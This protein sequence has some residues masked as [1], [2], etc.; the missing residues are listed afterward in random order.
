[1]AYNEK[2]LAKLADLKALGTKQKEV[3]DAL[4]AR[5]DT[6]E[7]VGSQANVLEGVK[8]NGTALAIANKMVDILIATG[9]KNGSISVNGADV[10]IKGLAALAFKAKV[11]QSDLDDALAAVLEGKA[12]KATTLDGYGITNAYTKDEIN[13]KIS[14]VYKPAGSVVFAELPALSE[15]ILGNV[16][17]V[18][19]AFTTTANFVEGIST[20]CWLVS[21]TCPVML[22][23]KQERACLTRTSLRPSRISWTALRLAQ[24]SMSIPPTPLL[25]AACTRPP[26]MKRAM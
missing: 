11:S 9:S 4:A 20:M 10:A 5:V 23:R 21:L 14:A 13:A 8:V 3:A 12:D 6:L 7:K 19:D 16:Y 18:T 2:H 15:S 1:M 26:W 25:P 22:K 24:T 17:N